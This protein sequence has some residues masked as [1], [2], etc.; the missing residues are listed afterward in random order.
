VSDDT[1]TSCPL[2]RRKK[3]GW[4]LTVTEE[5]S[6]VAPRDF[7]DARKS[8]LSPLGILLMNFGFFGIQFSFGLQQSAVNPI[9][10]FIGPRP[11]S[12]RC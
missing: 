4:A 1:A 11:R 12:C 7:D 3:R 9:F 10:T 5:S 6:D 8:P 2:L